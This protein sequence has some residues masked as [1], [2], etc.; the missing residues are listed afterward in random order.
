[1]EKVWKAHCHKAYEM[2]RAY[3]HGKSC[4]VRCEVQPC[5]FP[6]RL[7]HEKTVRVPSVAD[8]TFGCLVLS[9]IDVGLPHLH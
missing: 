9:P 5:R 2:G 4:G 1:M 8:F 3:H 6:R 7:S